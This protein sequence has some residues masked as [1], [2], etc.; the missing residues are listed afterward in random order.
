MRS[1]FSLIELLIVVAL[2]G[3][4]SSSVVVAANPTKRLAQARDAQ[5]KTNI[6]E[7]ANA[8]QAN[9]T[10]F[11][12]YPQENGCDSSIGTKAN[13]NCPPS[14]PTGE[15]D[16]VSPFYQALVGQQLLKVLPVDPKNDSTYYYRYEPK[17]ANQ[18][19]CKDENTVCRF[20][21]G[22][23]LESP[24]DPASPVFR[25]SDDETLNDGVGCKEVSNFYK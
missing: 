18:N 5:R 21:I 13:G 7:I 20:W 3:I 11:G 19:P 14:S 17:G 9:Y 10:T 22:A 12:Q 2:L 4:L 25:C 6:G 16:V 24:S 8:L 1:G 15:W 23:R